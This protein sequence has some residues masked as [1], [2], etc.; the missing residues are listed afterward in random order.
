MRE[1]P[2]LFE[3]STRCYFLLL[4]WWAITAN[5]WIPLFV[6]SN[7]RGTST[8]RALFQEQYRAKLGPRDSVTAF[9]RVGK[10]F[11]YMRLNSILKKVSVHE[12]TKYVVRKKR[13]FFR[14]IMDDSMWLEPLQMFPPHT[15]FAPVPVNAGSALQLLM[16]WERMYRSLRRTQSH[17]QVCM[18]D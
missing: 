11:V 10:G 8:S 16:L 2:V 12:A 14:N 18:P 5:T 17:K 1:S 9:S 13:L 7:L 6:S 15:P 3:F 4:C